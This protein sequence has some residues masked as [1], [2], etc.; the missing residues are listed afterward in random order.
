MLRTAA[1]RFACFVRLPDAVRM[2][3]ESFAS[4]A[5]VMHRAACTFTFARR[6]VFLVFLVMG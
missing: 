4:S 2:S 5:K 6:F 1:V 3:R